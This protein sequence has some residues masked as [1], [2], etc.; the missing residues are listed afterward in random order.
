MK[1]K[2]KLQKNTRSRLNTKGTFLEE[3]Q[4]VNQRQWEEIDREKKEL[5]R[6]R[7]IQRS[8]IALSHSSIPSEVDKA[9]AELK[10][11]LSEEPTHRLSILTLG[12][13]YRHK[14]QDL[15]AAIRELQVF[16]N[17]KADLTERDVDYADVNYNISCY[18]SLKQSAA[19]ELKDSAGVE[20]FGNKAL[21]ALQLAV[22]FSPDNKIDA[23]ADKDFA[24]I[25]EMRP[26]DFNAITGD[27]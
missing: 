26:D 22:E 3:Q 21:E 25:C 8:E 14:K 6:D 15:D 20:T 12:R 4:R 27:S 7:A 9:I 18:Y 11:V 2:R 13:I 24:S 1:N 17:K 19:K 23:K 10:D 5:R 16:V